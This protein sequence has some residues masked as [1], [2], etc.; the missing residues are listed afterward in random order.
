MLTK[1]GIK[2]MGGYI[3]NIYVTEMRYLKN[4][5]M[6]KAK[7]D[8]REYLLSKESVLMIIKDPSDLEWVNK[9]LEKRSE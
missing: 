3:S 7:S 9:E 6:W 2:A 1:Q 8:N 5:E 4:E